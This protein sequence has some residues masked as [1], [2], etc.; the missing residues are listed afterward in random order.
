[1]FHTFPR[2][3]LHLICVKNTFNLNKVFN[4]DFRANLKQI[5]GGNWQKFPPGFSEIV[6]IS[7]SFGSDL[8]QPP[9]SVLTDLSKPSPN[10]ALVFMC[11][12]YKSFENTVEKGEIAH[13]K[14][15]HLFLQCFLPVQRT[16]CHFYQI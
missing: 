13:N 1:M 14:Q 11:L 5:S 12:Q 6:K 8:N 16:F 3:T 9:H 10:Q 2:L 4:K 7:L 15:F